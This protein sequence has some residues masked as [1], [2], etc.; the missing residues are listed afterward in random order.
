MGEEYLDCFKMRAGHGKDVRSS[1]NQR[2]GQR[3]AAQ[4]ANVYA[5]DFTHL[6][7]IQTRRLAADCVNTGRRYFDVFAIAKQPPKQALGDRA[8]ADIARTN[9]E[10]AF[11][12]EAPGASA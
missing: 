1:F 2:T 6:H 5:F 4:V 9:K 10:N 7:G 12:D 3:L 11:H 8:S